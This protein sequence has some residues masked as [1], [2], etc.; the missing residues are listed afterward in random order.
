MPPAKE[1]DTGRSDRDKRL[2]GIWNASIEKTSRSFTRNE[3]QRPTAVRLRHTRASM[4][5]LF[6][7]S[8]R[9]QLQLN[10]TMKLPELSHLLVWNNREVPHR[11]AF[12]AI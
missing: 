1:S 4:I 5:G 12:K 7:R 6:P 10:I 3:A 11:A 9:I 2:A 8:P